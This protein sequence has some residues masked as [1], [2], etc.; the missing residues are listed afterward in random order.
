MCDT[1][2]A[3][4]SA[5]VGQAMLFGKNSDR[6]RNEA[7]AVE[8][9]ARAD[10]AADA[11][12]RCTHIAIPQVRR[13]HAVIL[14]RPFWIWGAEMGA[15]EY[16]VAIGNEGLHARSPAPE[17]SALTGMDLL[18]LA[19]E[20]AATAA[21]AVEV[22]TNLLEGYGQ[23][24]NCGHL[25]ADY[26][27]N[28]FII[29]DP[30]EAFVLETVGREW[31]VARAQGVRSISNIYSI[32]RDVQR[33]SEGLP[34]L[35]RNSGWSDDPAPSYAEVIT[36]PHR[37]H[38]GHAGR[39][40]ARSTALL[41]SPL[42]TLNAADMM[43]IL[44][45]HGT[46]AES[47]TDWSPEHATE[48]SICAHAGTE[49]RSGQTVGSMVSDL[50]LRDAVHWVT[51]TAAPC[52]SIFK[53]ALID[54]A[55]PLHGLRPTDRSDLGTLWWRHER[56]HRAALMSDF[57]AFINAIRGQRDALEADFLTR[58]AA[59]LNGGSA[60]ERS[61]VVAECWKDAS[62][63]E[64]R[65]LTQIKMMERNH[66]TAYRSAWENMSRIAGAEPST[67]KEIIS[68]HRPDKSL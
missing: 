36:N 53:P 9:V 15:N 29:A 24:G 17:Q 12:A 14:C 51:G 65:W 6:Q 45:D 28:G 50:R 61:R 7:Q 2:L 59:V 54:V 68:Q 37:E 27:N 31:L 66:D 19:L 18:R 13:T 44:R 3:T 56:L 40:R 58:M 63:L 20:R 34:A 1:I 38:I 39:R 62:E 57:S 43:R 10:H 30:N 67:A 47:R 48:R 4:P 55:L 52:I 8:I 46:S 26:Y 16:G 64:D 22:I 25:H 33:T 5:T 42:G 49:D 21:E 23:G 35:V 11:E 32:G 60:A 41:N